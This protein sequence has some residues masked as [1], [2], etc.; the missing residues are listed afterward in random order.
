MLFNANQAQDYA[1]ERT[2]DMLRQ[3][4]QERLANAARQAECDQR[5]TEVRETRRETQKNRSPLWARV[6]TLF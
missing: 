1:R 5:A 4:E 2:K 3:A 6:W